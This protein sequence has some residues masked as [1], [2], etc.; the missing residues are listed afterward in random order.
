MPQLDGFRLALRVAAV[1]GMS[2]PRTLL[3]SG[4][5]HAEQLT[6]AS[7]AMVIGV[8]AKPFTASDLLPILDLLE[9]ARR[10]CPGVL[11]PLCPCAGKGATVGLIG[12]RRCDTADYAACRFYSTT[13]GKSLQD[14]IGN[15]AAASN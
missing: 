7:P 14:W 12:R 3:M 9:Q 4:D 11:M 1:L 10:R 6:W 5:N 13:C 15:R 2:P 8:L